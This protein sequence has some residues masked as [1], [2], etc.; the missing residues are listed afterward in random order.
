M[1]YRSEWF[2]SDP[3]GLVSPSA[4]PVKHLR[5]QDHFVNMTFCLTAKND[6]EGFGAK[7][8]EVM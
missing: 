4:D 7:L 6:Y 3:T 5:V 8:G 2:L 1:K